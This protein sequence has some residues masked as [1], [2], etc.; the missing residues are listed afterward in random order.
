[1]R[2]WGGGW[3]YPGSSNVKTS[4]SLWSPRELTSASLLF[5]T[6]IWLARTLRSSPRQRRVSNGWFWAAAGLGVLVIVQVVGGAFVAGLRAGS[7]FNTWPFMDGAL[8][9]EGLWFFS[10]WWKNLVENA[11][12]V[13]FAHRLL[14]YLIL[15]YVAVLFIVS[16]RSSLV[17]PG[18]RRSIMWIAALILIQACLGVMT[19]LSAAQLPIAVAHLVTAFAIVGLLAARLADLSN[20]TSRAPVHKLELNAAA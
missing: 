15:L 18:F 20:A 17:Q 14:G 13:Q 16:R 1:M 2:F 19:V 10:P 6:C 7:V 11:L 12:S 9:P 5:V 4:P 8:I 3:A